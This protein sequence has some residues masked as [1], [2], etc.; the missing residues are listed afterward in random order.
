MLDFGNKIAIIIGTI[1]CLVIIL[2]SSSIT[3]VPTGYVGVKTRFGKVQAD[4]IQE[5]FRRYIELRYQN[6]R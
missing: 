6:L 2:I 4:V 5:V 3:T 1:V